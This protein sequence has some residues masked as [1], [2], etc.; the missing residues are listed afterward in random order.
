MPGLSRRD[1]ELAK[2]IDALSANSDHETR[3]LTEQ[4]ATA[5]DGSRDGS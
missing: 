2:A 5:S 1:V 4:A 3:T